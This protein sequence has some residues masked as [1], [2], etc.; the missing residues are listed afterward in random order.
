[1]PSFKTPTQSQIDTAVQRMTSPDFAAYFLSRLENPHW[2][3]P[4]LDKGIFASPP[5]VSVE[6]TSSTFPHW[7]ASKYLTRM[8]TVA[9]GEVAQIFSGIETDNTAVVFDMV[10]SALA[11]PLPVA[12]SLVPALSHAARENLLWIAFK[13]AC[14]LC[15]RLAEGSVLDA[16]LELASALFTPTITEDERGQ[17]RC[18]EYWYIE[19]LEKVTIA[20]AKVNANELLP[21]LCEWL[22]VA[23]DA[24][25]FC[26]QKTGHD[27]SDAWRPAIEEH[28][29]NYAFDFAGKLVGCVRSG[30]EQ[31]IRSKQISLE[32]CLK[33]LDDYSY[34]IYRRLQIHLINEFAE[35]NTDLACLTIMD[36]DLFDEDRSKHEYAMLVGRRLNLLTS[37]QR[38]EWFSW[39]SAGPDMSDYNE[40]FQK[41][42][43][44]DATEED[45]QQRIHH[46]Q[47]RK[48]Y[49]VR[50]HLDGERKDFYEAML[51]K[52]GPPMFSDMN[53][54][55][56]HYG[57]DSPMS[58]DELSELEFEQAVEKVCAWQAEK[59]DTWGP[60]A[61]GLA[62]AFTRYVA[63]SPGDFSKQ[64]ITM[65]DR[66]AI[67]VRSYLGQ[68]SEEIKAGH[69]VDLSAVIE[70]CQWVV[71]QPVKVKTEPDED[72]D[73]VDRGWQWTRDQI[74]ELLGNVCKAKTG[75]SSTYSLDNFRNGIWKLLESLCH[76]SA[77]SDILRDISE[78]D[79]RVHDYLD[80]G[81][82]S[83]HGKAVEAVLEYVRWVANHI[84]EIDGDKETI[85][86]GFDS[87]PEA[88]EKLD[89]LI[90]EGNRSV[91]AMAIIGSRIG[92]LQWV[93]TKW[94]SDNAMILFNLEGIEES[95][96]LAEGWAAWNAFLV[97]VRP[98]IEFYNA[99]K[100][101]FAYAVEQAAKVEIA[102]SSRE[103]PM[104]YL[105][106]HLMVLYGRGQL[107]LDEND[108]LLQEFL[109]DSKPEIRRHAIGFVGRSL[110]GDA[111]IPAEV[112]ERF[113]I[114]WRIY[115]DGLGKQDAKDCPG[116][117]L[118]G[119]WFTSKKFPDD[120]ALAQLEE[121]ANIDPTPEPDHSIAERLA[122]ISSVDIV[123]SVHILR[124]MVY[125][126]K[127][128]W[129]IYGWRDSLKPI[130]ERAISV[131]GA[132]RQEA[133][134]LI[135]YLGRRGYNELGELLR[136][137]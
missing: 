70:L 134:Q 129:R 80:L 49:W 62:A 33:I 88:R 14:D 4:L 52:H 124:Q 77:E 27:S 44:R 128:G 69:A 127:E 1:M 39:I 65:I 92:L 93:D 54:G 22:K 59:E 20:L 136:Q 95:P 122:G 82:N 74:S 64:A 123:K 71:K 56:V 90:V 17:N 100:P 101:Q 117:L 10:E 107:G 15:V 84:K 135:D 35:E 85:P 34:F 94:L 42:N 106:E 7:P 108:G 3:K 133:E 58:L 9:P 102:D 113:Q 8:A 60:N 121:F 105:G 31:T 68:M 98:H 87:I 89:W 43:N 103:Q 83:P 99:F 110:E 6:G 21:R 119:T 55:P 109:T 38:D 79:P 51:T 67:Y 130:L 63:T 47:Y 96:S 13:D 137:T 29:G 131:P 81:I 114:L 26:N 40:L 76:D 73:M 19:G 111:E 41:R 61:T 104:Y 12:A 97:W 48:L 66:P 37:E 112:I 120:W 86:G 125:G 126:D 72:D 5:P 78:E 28:S 32:D 23:V 25:R 36:Y 53:T 75:N 115:W 46:W 2:I 30:F 11:M 16:S 45:R 116:A 50:E 91:T 118:F 132:A 57:D 18:D 24:K